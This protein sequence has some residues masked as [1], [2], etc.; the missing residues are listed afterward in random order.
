MDLSRRRFLEGV[1]AASLAASPSI[2]AQAQWEP[3]D[4]VLYSGKIVTVDDAFSISNAIA[5]KD[6]RSAWRQFRVPVLNPEAVTK[7]CGLTVSSCLY[8]AGQAFKTGWG[9]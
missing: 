5:V 8:A 1:G 7:T 6:Q 4:L 2:E 9:R 3:A